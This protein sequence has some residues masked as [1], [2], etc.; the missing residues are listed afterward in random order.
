M[1]YYL[2]GQ[3]KEEWRQIFK[4]AIIFLCIGFFI[5]TG[6]GMY[7]RYLQTEDDHREEVK[8]L[9]ASVQY[10]QDHWTPIKQV[11]VKGKKK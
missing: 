7:W 2:P 5:G 4:T 10:Y 8:R 11:E 3:R 1:Q 6:W 9:K